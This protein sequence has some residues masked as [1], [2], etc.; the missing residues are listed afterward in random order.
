MRRLENMTMWV[1][2]H[3]P[4]KLVYWCAMRV[5]SYATCG[6]YGHESP[7]DLLAMDAVKRWPTR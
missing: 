6:Q 1:A 3:L 7:T 5:F 2:W 4:K